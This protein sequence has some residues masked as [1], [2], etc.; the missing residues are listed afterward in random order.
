VTLLTI[1]LE[2]APDTNKFFTAPEV[3]GARTE[4]IVQGFRAEPAGL[5]SRAEPSKYGAS[6]IWMASRHSGPLEN[7]QCLDSLQS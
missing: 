7:W 3:F 1:S 5:E 4:T 6:S 2:A